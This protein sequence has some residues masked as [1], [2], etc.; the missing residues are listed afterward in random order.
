[1]GPISKRRAEKV[2][3]GM[4]G[5]KGREREGGRE[6]GKLGEGRDGRGGASPK[7]FG[8]EPALVK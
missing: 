2:G 7:Y 1:M 6:G 8:L 4:G 3:R 5:E